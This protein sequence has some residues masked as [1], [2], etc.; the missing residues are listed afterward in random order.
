M[1]AEKDIGQRTQI[2]IETSRMWLER[3]QAHTEIHNKFFCSGRREEKSQH[4]GH[5][6]NKRKRD[7]NKRTENFQG[8]K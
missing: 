3:K 7:V 5:T 8:S 4:K 2:E 1:T 6:G